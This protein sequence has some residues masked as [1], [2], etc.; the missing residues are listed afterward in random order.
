MGLKEV[1]QR[2]RVI[3]IAPHPVLLDL[4]LLLLLARVL[5]ADFRGGFLFRRLL[6]NIVVG[7]AR[8]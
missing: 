6:H 4:L 8:A 3:R 5:F 2:V 7:V 1:E